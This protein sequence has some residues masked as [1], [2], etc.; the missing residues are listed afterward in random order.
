[1]KVQTIPDIVNKAIKEYQ[2]QQKPR[3][4]QALLER[5]ERLQP[6]TIL[7]IGFGSGGMLWALAQLPSVKKII[8]IDIEENFKERRELLKKECLC[9]IQYVIGDSNSDELATALLEDGFSYYRPVSF[10]LIDGNHDYEHCKKDYELY[11]ETVRRGGIVAFHDIVAHPPETMCA[12]DKVWKEI[13]TLEYQE[14]NKKFINNPI[15]IVYPPNNWG[16]FGVLYVR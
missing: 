12:V 6:E 5:L 2:A 7:E 15:E 4:L 10:L 14:K 8:S 13:Q 3:E 16:G 9:E 1:M 11:A